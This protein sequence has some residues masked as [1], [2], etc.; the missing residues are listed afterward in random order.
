MK[1]EDMNEEEL[2]KEYL[3]QEIE[4]NKRDKR[5]WRIRLIMM[6]IGIGL[7]LLMLIPL[8]VSCISIRQQGIY[9]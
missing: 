3:K 7:V 2:R 9:Y 4:R 1:I 6:C 8:F 5:I